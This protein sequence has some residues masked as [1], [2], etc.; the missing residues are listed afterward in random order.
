VIPV[1]ARWYVRYDAPYRDVKKL[2]AERGITVDHVTIY[3]WV[4]TVATKCACLPGH[5]RRGSR[6]CRTAQTALQ[7]GC[8]CLHERATEVDAVSDRPGENASV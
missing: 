1:A 6:A 4:Q 5:R 7:N 3:R 2:L 8:A